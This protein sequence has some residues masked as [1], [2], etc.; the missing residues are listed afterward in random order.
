[1]GHVETYRRSIVARL[2]REQTRRQTEW[3]IVQSANVGREYPGPAPRFIEGE[4]ADMIERLNHENTRLRLIV[5]KL[6][7]IS[8]GHPDLWFYPFA[9]AAMELRRFATKDEKKHD[10][11]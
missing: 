7:N 6:A 8:I 3:L 2:R 4:A 10:G 1:M 11:S 5:T 9:A